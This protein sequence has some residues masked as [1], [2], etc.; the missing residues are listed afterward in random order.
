MSC[1]IVVVVSSAQA[2]LGHG[3]PLL[4][5]RFV[6]NRPPQPIKDG[7]ASMSH[8]P[9]MAGGDFRDVVGLSAVLGADMVASGRAQSHFISEMR[10]VNMR[11]A[12][13]QSADTGSC[14]LPDCSALR[15][16]TVE[17]RSLGRRVGVGTDVR[18]D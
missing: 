4:E 6:R 13:C 7:R 2:L 14:H 15:A 1:Y 9:V 5:V 16:G 10:I 12:R 3:L 8:S 17:L 18:N 11:A